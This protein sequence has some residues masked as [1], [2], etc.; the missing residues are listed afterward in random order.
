MLHAQPVE[1]AHQQLVRIAEALVNVAARVP[2]IQPR[3][4]DLEVCQRG[5]RCLRCEAERGDRVLSAG[6]SDEDLPF[7][8]A[9]EVEEDLSAKEPLLHCKCTRH[10]RLLVYSDEALD[11]SVRDVVRSQHGQRCCYADAVVSP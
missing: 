4:H 1:E 6:T 3:D 10:A 9:V 8:F 11:G 7:V 2:A 5:W